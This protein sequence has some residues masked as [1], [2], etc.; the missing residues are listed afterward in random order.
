MISYNCFY[1]LYVQRYHNRTPSS[2]A[3]IVRIEHTSLNFQLMFWK[4]KQKLKIGRNDCTRSFNKLLVIHNF[5]V[6]I[7]SLIWY[8]LYLKGCKSQTS[9]SLNFLNKFRICLDGNEKFRSRLHPLRMYVNINVS[10][11]SNLHY[12]LR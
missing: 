2:T 11:F 1:K 8:R 5:G 7:D 6:I 3:T 10:S 9:V 12:G 4:T